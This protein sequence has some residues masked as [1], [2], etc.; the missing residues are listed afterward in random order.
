VLMLENR[1]F[2]HFFGLSGRP[3]LARPQDPGFQAGATDRA[4]HDPG[5]EY[6]DV[7]TQ[8]AGTGFDPAQTSPDAAMTRAK[9]SCPGHR[10]P[11]TRT[12]QDVDKNRYGRPYEIF[13]TLGDRTPGGPC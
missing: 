11:T 6:P 10:T 4:A 13:L 2:D 3:G 5:D 12:S 1:S 7:Q 8:L 9:H